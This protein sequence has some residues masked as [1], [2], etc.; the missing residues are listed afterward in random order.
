MSVSDET[1]IFD[2]GNQEPKDIH[3]TMV[4]VYAALEEKGYNPFNQIVGY[5]MSG[6][7]AYIPR[8]HDARNLIKRHERDEI[9]EEL[10][11]AYLKK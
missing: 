6:D 3:E 10:V 4:L 11:H 5:L 9:I 2:F 8:L 7:P 1:A